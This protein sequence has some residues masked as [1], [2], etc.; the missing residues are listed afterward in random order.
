MTNN[1]DTSKRRFPGFVAALC[2]LLAAT[3]VLL[4]SCE[5]LP[6]ASKTVT[7]RVVYGSE[8][9][10]WMQA[11]IQEY[12]AA[13][14]K[15]P[16]GSQ[17]VVEG[18]PMGSVESIRAIVE[19]RIQPAVWSPASS[20]Y[21][22]QANADWHKAHTG[23]LVTGSPPNLVLSPVVIAM[24]EPMAKVL[25]WP[26]QAIGWADIA[27]LAT[28]DRGWAEY[29]LPEW[30]GLQVRAHAPQLQQQRD[31]RRAGGSV[32]SGGQAA[33]PHGGRSQK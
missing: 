1:N 32:C 22:A 5:G 20:L 9:Q 3:A 33:Q 26:D 17:I 19:G 30:G 16:G 2:L 6:F 24:W 31:R 28:S 21:L 10:E 25:G 8:K 23:E 13:K 29:D 14:H 15:T 4:A 27:R 7:L 18:I 11:L 12:N